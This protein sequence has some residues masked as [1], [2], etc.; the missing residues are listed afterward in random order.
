MT[1]LEAEIGIIQMSLVFCTAMF[2]TS[3]YLST[4]EVVWGILSFGA[5]FITSLMWTTITPI[6][7][8]YSVALFF[9]GIGFIFLLMVIIQLL[10]SIGKRNYEPSELD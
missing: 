5:W 1:M 4:K 6:P 10:R 2:F 7:G 9:Q 3:F 8:T